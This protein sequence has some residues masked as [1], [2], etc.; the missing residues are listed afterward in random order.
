MPAPAT[1]LGQVS[2]LL[3]VERAPAVVCRLE[4][5]HTPEPGGAGERQF[6]LVRDTTALPGGRVTQVYATPYVPGQ[7]WLD[8]WQFGGVHLDVGAHLPG[9]PWVPLHDRRPWVPART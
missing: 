9:A 8:G 3:H 2:A 6:V 4:H 1:A 5:L 7:P